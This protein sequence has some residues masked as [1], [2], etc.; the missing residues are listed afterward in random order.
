M[1]I[2]QLQDLHVSS[3]NQNRWN[4]NGLIYQLNKA[5]Y[6][7][8]WWFSF[9]SS[10]SWLRVIYNINLFCLCWF[11]EARDYYYWLP[12]NSGLRHSF[13]K[14]LNTFFVEGRHGGILSDVNG[15]YSHTYVTHGRKKQNFWMWTKRRVHNCI[16]QLYILCGC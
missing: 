6:F 11:W 5:K 9:S 8:K 2:N 10:R 12:P 4:S 1:S 14:L 3:S 15:V 16:W 13:C 7:H